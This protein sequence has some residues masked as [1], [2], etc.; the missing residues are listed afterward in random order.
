MTPVTRRIAGTALL[1]LVIAVS[2]VGFDMRFSRTAD[3]TQFTIEAPESGVGMRPGVDIKSRGVPIGTVVDVELRDDGRAVMTGR[4]DPGVRV[5]REGLDVSISPK[6]FFGAKQIELRYPLE[7][8]GEP[9][10]LGEGDVIALS[11][12]FTEV[13]D[14]LQTLQPLLAGIDDEDLAN[15]FEAAAELEGEGPRIARALEVNAEVAEFGQDISDPALRSARLLTSLSDQ[16]ARGA[17]EFD[18]L[19]RVLPDAVAILSERQEE[20]DT[21]LEALSS[22]ALT[23]AE[24]IAVD[25]ERFDTLLDEGDVVGA[26]LE[27]NVDSIPSIVEGLRIFA[28][29][30][31]ERS[32]FMDDGTIY[33][34][35]KIFIEQEQLQQLVE[36]LL[37]ALEG[38]S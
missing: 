21:N 16:L 33:V 2:T 4:L 1:I 22:F 18:R 25:R 7:Q 9:P 14:V 5:P 3:T 26:F 34:P 32:P 15:L 12:E 17:D 24:W 35:F 11:S 10:F 36:P 31:S 38:A 37:G 28:Q 19:N 13:E 20:I 29:A 6:T 8:H 27:R 30:Q 23:T